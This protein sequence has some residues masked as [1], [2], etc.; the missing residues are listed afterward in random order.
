MELFI[1]SFSTYRTIKKATVTSYSF[2][3]D[4]LDLETSSV[5]VADQ[6]ITRADTG[7]WAIV[8]GKVWSISNVKPENGGTILTLVP[9]LES[10]SRLI[11]FTQQNSSQTVGGFIAEQM[12]RHWTQG[13]DPT[14]AI[15]YLVVSNSDTTPLASP[16]LD[17]SGSFSLSVYARLMRKSY[18]IVTEFSDA[19]G[20]LRCSIYKASAKSRQISFFD[21]RS[22]LQSVEY[23]SSGVAK[24]SVIHDVDTGTKDSNGDKIYKRERSVWYLSEDGEASQVIPPRRASGEWG[25]LYIQG[26]KDVESKVVETFAKNKA[27]HKLEFWSE[28]DLDV[29]TDCTFMVYGELLR[30]YISYKRITSSDKRFYYKSG[31]LATTATEKLKGII[32]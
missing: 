29:Q 22:R 8:F 5:T 21:G 31:E 23:S 18:R 4:A 1:K 26:D 28:L 3:L 13:D 11:E 12:H 9:P 32:K 6:Q 30:S 17:S 10:F 24:L 25:I 27:N 20:S 15:P 19:G 16:E 14:Y 2:V 7:N